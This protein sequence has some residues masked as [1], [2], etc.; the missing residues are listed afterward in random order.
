MNSERIQTKM[1]H[2]VAQGLAAQPKYISSRYFYD[3]QGD[4]LFQQ[5]M[6]M[7]E[8]YPTTCEFEIFESYKEKLLDYLPEREWDLVE[9]GAGDGRKTKVLLEHFLQ[10]QSRFAYFPID[11]SGAVLHHLEQDLA[12][13]L[14]QLRVKTLNYEYFHALEELNKMDQNPRLVLFLGGNIGNF[15]PAEALSFYQSLQAVLRPGDLLLNGIDLRKNPLTILEAYN[16]KTG[17]TRDFNLNLL[18]RFNRELGANFNT[19][20]FQHYP[21]YNPV[22]GEALSYLMSTCEQ[23]VFIEKLGQTFHFAANEPIHTEVSQ[24]YSFAEIETLAQKTGFALVEHFTDAKG[25]F[26]DSL[27]RKI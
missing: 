3:A 18:T 6:N 22:S 12:K 21:T 13:T 20:N 8:Y 5:I 7:P 1:A 27:W 4:K 10:Q 15:K 16:D 24:K 23:E 9:L 25:W 19:K 14:P 17:I 11:I 2:D 26:C